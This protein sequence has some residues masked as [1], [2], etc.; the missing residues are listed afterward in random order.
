MLHSSW[1]VWQFPEPHLSGIY[2]APFKCRS[3]NWG[4]IVCTTEV[5]EPYRLTSQDGKCTAHLGVSGDVC[6]DPQFG[7]SSCGCPTTSSTWLWSPRDFFF[8]TRVLFCFLVFC[9]LVWKL[10][11]TILI[12]DRVILMLA[13]VVHTFA[14]EAIQMASGLAAK[15]VCPKVFSRARPLQFNTAFFPTYKT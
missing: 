9:F 6:A 11:S 4:S 7:N 1:A 2:L 8:L 10:C 12:D 14:R 5:V 15:C 3:W 13:S